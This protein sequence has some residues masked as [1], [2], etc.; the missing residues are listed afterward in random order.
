M[1]FSFG[2]FKKVSA[3]NAGI[4]IDKTQMSSDAKN[5]SLRGNAYKEKVVN[6]ILSL[7]MIFPKNSDGVKVTKRN[8]NAI[9]SRYSKLKE[10]PKNNSATQYCATIIM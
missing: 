10:A 3:S 6:A 7:T 8:T 9:G 5:T 4:N 1:N 2:A